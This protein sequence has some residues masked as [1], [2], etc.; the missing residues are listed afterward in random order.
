VNTANKAVGI[1]GRRGDGAFGERVPVAAALTEPGFLVA[2]GPISAIEI[3]SETK[4]LA[5]FRRKI[6]CF[7]WCSA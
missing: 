3:G 2:K 4:I 5:T 1:I 7:R 6:G